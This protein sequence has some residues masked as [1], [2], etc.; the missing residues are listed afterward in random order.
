MTGARAGRRRFAIGAVAALAL[1][2][3]GAVARGPR[4]ATKLVVGFQ[5]GG[6]SDRVA[7]A[8]AP[9]LARLTGR[10][11]IVE[12]VPAANGAPAIARVAAS[13]PDGDTLLFANAAIAHPDNAAAAASLR[14]IVV[15]S[16]T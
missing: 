6:A 16:T 13:E 2:G 4:G 12:N 9:E 10:A 5:P 3:A 8:L 7:R 11:A 15:T 14:P 1:G